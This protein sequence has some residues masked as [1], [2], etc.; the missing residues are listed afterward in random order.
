MNAQLHKYD[1]NLYNSY[2]KILAQADQ[3]MHNLLTHLAY[4]KDSSNYELVTPQVVT[5]DIWL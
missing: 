3:T 2:Q 1:L 5:V 4:L